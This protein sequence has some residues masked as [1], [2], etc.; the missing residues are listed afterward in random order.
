MLLTGK[1]SVAAHWK[2]RLD[3]MRQRGLSTMCVM[4][5][6]TLTV[7]SD[8]F[9]SASNSYSSQKSVR[10]KTCPS[11]KRISGEIHECDYCSCFL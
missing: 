2:Q 1:E 6:D 4:S 9:T 7:T 10:K 8:D 11:Y 5:D 3:G